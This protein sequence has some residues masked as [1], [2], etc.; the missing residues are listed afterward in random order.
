MLSGSGTYIVVDHEMF[1]QK[2]ERVIVVWFW[3]PIS[4]FDYEVD[5]AM[6]SAHWYIS[7]EYFGQF[8]VTVNLHGAC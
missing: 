7:L 2:S 6:L 4:E 1:I 5:L 8:P 3:K